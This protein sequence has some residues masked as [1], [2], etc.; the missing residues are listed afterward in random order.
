VHGAVF[1]RHAVQHFGL[2][3]D[4][5]AAWPN[6]L[7]KADE[8]VAEGGGDGDITHSFDVGEGSLVIGRMPV[9]IPDFAVN[10]ER[11][12]MFWP[13]AAEEVPKHRVHWIVTAPGESGKAIERARLLTQSVCSLLS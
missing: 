10:A 5:Q 2:P 11:P 9:P 6:T 1:P 12:P 3:T 4:F 8:A 7:I 13:K